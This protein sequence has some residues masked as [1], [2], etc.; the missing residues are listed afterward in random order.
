[1]NGQKPYIQK[2]YEKFVMMLLSI[3][4]NAGV[5][6]NKKTDGSVVIMTCDHK[7]SKDR[8]IYIALSK[9]DGGLLPM[10]KILSE[11]D[12][13]KLIPNFESVENMTELFY[14]T[15]E[16]EERRTVED[17]GKPMK[18]PEFEEWYD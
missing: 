4:T 18:M 16:N 17:F 14:G 6:W 10:A 5:G 12:C 3:L 7:I 2:A 1:M 11:S 8:S 15:L 9:E 13:E